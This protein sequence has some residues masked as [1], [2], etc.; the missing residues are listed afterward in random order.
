[1]TGSAKRRWHVAPSLW[2]TLVGAAVS[3]G[4]AAHERLIWPQILG[5]VLVALVATS[6]LAVASP[7]RFEVGIEAPTHVRVGESFVTVLRIRN[8]AG[9][10][11]GVVVRQQWRAGPAI[12]A[13]LTAFVDVVARRG[14]A[15][16]RSQ[17][18][19]LARGMADVSDVDV[20]V[21]GPFGFFSRT[22]H[23]VVRRRLVSVPAP[24]RPLGFL[25]GSGLRFG[26]AAKS[27]HGSADDLRG[28]RDWRAGDQI[29]QVHWRSVVRTGRM[30]VVERD[31]APTGSVV[32]VV[33][34][35][36]K[37]GRPVK[38]AVF[39][40]ALSVASSTAIAALAQGIQPC[41]VLQ[42]RDFGGIVHSNGELSL[43]E[44]F[45]RIGIVRPADDALLEHAL[46]H[47]AH[48]GTLL[49]V[50][51]R[52]TPAAWRQRLLEAA[53]SVG[54][55]AIDV[56]RDLSVRTAGDGSHTAPAQVS[57]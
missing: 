57:K 8:H 6:F 4:L 16:V 45:A 41:L 5:C 35:P 49:V 3:F 19:P 24:A 11:R 39:E 33:A 13:E 47:A 22:S 50:A 2:P 38:D 23:L 40:S 32:I 18:M 56:T 9:L 44:S 51:A 10:R 54:V 26:A 37:R 53:A 29:N 31:G 55:V 46:S 7:I 25:A 20:E 34:A 43:L 14:E 28:V 27:G 17:R 48:G 12:V 21:A 1:V 30:T 52:T 15:V 36:G 42:A